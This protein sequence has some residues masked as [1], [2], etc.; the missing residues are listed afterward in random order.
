MNFAYV[1]QQRRRLHLL[2][3]ANRQA[4]LKGDKAR[5][6]ADPDRVTGCIRITSFDG[7]HHQLQKFL[8]T[9]L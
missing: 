4:E 3:L 2:H 5:D 6:L 8:A 1:V 7:L 9:V